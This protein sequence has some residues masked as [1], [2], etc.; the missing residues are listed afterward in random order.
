VSLKER[1]QKGSAATLIA[2]S[3]PRA[4]Y[5][6]PIAEV[7]ALVRS[8]FFSAN[9]WA[10]MSPIQ[11]KTGCERAKPVRAWFPLPNGLG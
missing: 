5:W 6:R 3:S 2:S 7:P 10:G 8:G 11:P 9:A 1:A 4:A